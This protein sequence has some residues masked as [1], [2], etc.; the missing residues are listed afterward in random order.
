MN[1]APSACAAGLRSARL[2]GVFTATLLRTGPARADTLSPPTSSLPTSCMTQ[3]AR[4]EHPAKR[5]AFRMPDGGCGSC[6]ARPRSPTA[7][8]ARHSVVARDPG[9]ARSVRR[10]PA[11]HAH[12]RPALGNPWA[13]SP[14]I[15]CRRDQ[16][17]LWKSAPVM[18]K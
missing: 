5:A 15:P 9:R 17:R 13:L 14:L 12:R 10:R 6:S 2:P 16:A 7:P 18:P 1:V 11:G 8:A 4:T 3:V